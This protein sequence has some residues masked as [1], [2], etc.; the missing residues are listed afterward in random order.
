MKKI[1]NINQLIDI[2]YTTPIY[3]MIEGDGF[4]RLRYNQITKKKL[5]E[6]LDILPSLY[7][8]T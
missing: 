7:Y 8:S 6:V 1:E 2:L 5:S 4:K 3:L